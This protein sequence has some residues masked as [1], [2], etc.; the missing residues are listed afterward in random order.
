MQ[1][2]VVDKLF[3]STC[4]FIFPTVTTRDD[5]TTTYQNNQYRTWRG[6]ID[7]PCR[8]DITRHYRQAD[9]FGQ[10]VVVS[11]YRL[12]VPVGFE[13]EVEDVVVVDDATFQIRKVLDRQSYKATVELLLVK[14]N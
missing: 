12:H 3:P 9:I 5:G 14:V 10:D 7:I 6:S 11:D 1:E 13:F 8:L 4:H 2:A